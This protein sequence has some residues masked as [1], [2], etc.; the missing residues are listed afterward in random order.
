[1]REEKTWVAEAAEEVAGKLREEVPQRK[2][3]STKK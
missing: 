2:Y 1:M 3:S